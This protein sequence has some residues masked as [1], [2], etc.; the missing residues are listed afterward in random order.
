MYSNEG[1]YTD[2]LEA[3]ERKN[4]TVV[5]ESEESAKKRRIEELEKDAPES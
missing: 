3:K 4:G 5:R 2:Y 1:G